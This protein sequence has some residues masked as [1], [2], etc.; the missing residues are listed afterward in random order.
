MTPESNN[1]YQTVSLLVTL[2][3]KRCQ[4]IPTLT[5][6]KQHT[7]IVSRAHLADSALTVP[8][9]LNTLDKLDQIGYLVAAS[10]T[11]KRE[12]QALAEVLND[13]G[14]QTTLEQF[15]SS[16][17]DSLTI[18]QKQSVIRALKKI[19][20]AN[21]TIDE[22]VW[23]ADD[24]RYS[25]L[26]EMARPALANYTEDDIALV[27]LLPFRSIERLLEKLDTGMDFDQ[28][29]DVGTWYDPINYEFH[30]DGR[31]VPT[32][33]QGK[34]NVEHSI[35]ERVH[36]NLNDGVVWYDDISEHSARALKDALTR[37]VAKHDR[38]KNIFS[39]HHDR[40][41]FDKTAF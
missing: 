10:L 6:E 30:I 18:P 22:R 31:A 27:V 33:Y 14:Y 26:L 12:Y 40:L 29:K 1:V 16:E 15:K 23:L 37:F 39:V 38:L 13:E 25:T 11:E 34:P 41:E 36:E 7:L 5:V 8:V 19:T 35:L 3:K 32:S 28:I 4:H 20:P 21:Y 24:I 17:F 2:F 9:F